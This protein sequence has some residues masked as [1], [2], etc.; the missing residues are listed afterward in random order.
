[1]KSKETYL[2]SVRDVNGTTISISVSKDSLTGFIYIKGQG[3]RVGQI[4]SFIRIPIGFKN[5]FVL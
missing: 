3:Y 1:M 4:G 5:L 2:G